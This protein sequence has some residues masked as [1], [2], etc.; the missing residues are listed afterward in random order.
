MNFKERPSAE[1]RK[2]SPV[3]NLSEGIETAVIRDLAF[4]MFKLAR[5]L[6]ERALTYDTIVS[7]DASGRLV[8]LFVKKV[9]DGLRK[10]QNQPPIKINFIASG[11]FISESK[12]EGIKD[13]LDRNKNKIGKVLLVTE[14]IETGQS[15][16]EIIKILNSLQ[17]DSDLAALSVYRGVDLDLL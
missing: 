13:F 10:K 6:K 17:I 5:S 9:F 4:D 3:T 2:D 7:D 8:S 11:R 15:I 12:R 14:Y 16:S 1:T